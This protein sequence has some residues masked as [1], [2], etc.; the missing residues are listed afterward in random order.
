MYLDKKGSGQ[1]RLVINNNPHSF[2]EILISDKHAVIAV[3]KD[4]T[5]GEHS[6]A[7]GKGKAL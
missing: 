7:N 5:V 6:I 1:Q 3:I 4:S 2:V